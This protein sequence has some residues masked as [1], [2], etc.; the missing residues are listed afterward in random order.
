MNM[1]I[2]AKKDKYFIRNVAAAAGGELF[3]G[4]GLPVVV[5]STFLQI[6]LRSLGA[7]S[8]IVG[9]VPTFFFIG[10]SLFGLLAGYLTG[11]LQDK[12]KV[13]VATHLFGTLPIPAF[14]FFLLISGGG[15]NT[16]IVFLLL[17]G[18]FSLGVGLI[19][20]VW[21]NY[22]VKIFSETKIFRAMSVVMVTQSIAR[23]TCS[24]LILQTVKRYSMDPRASGFIFCIVGGVFLIGTCF[25]LLT[26][27]FSDESKVPKR[28]KNIFRHLR[29]T[30][31]L[32]FGNR[33]FLRFLASDIETFAVIGVISFYANYAV[34]Y[35]GISPAVASGLFVACLYGGH[36]T[37]HILFGWMDLLQLRG[38][39]LFG[40]TAA[41]IGIVC[42]LIFQSLPFLLIISYVL[43]IA[44]GIRFL[45]FPTAVKRI[46][47]QE[48]ATLYFSIAP[49]LV[50]PFSAGLPFV[51][52]V[53][54]D[55]LEHLGG[56]SYRLVF[57][58]Y[59]LVIGLAVIFLSKVRF[60]RR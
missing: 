35:C 32:A 59:G 2:E 46:S 54:L 39:F 3:W 56:L 15:N 30:S 16:I 41:A 12:R 14:G 6:F 55:G 60:P 17:Y 48:D 53:V 1:S 28:E 33:N 4:I 18:L 49:I 40:K 31:T 10:I 52:G 21:Q 11:H 25:Y 50:L 23:L 45:G 44:R 36:I 51:S 24:F 26:M 9:L 58:F 47:R 38:K 37:A 19:L 29:V 20:P 34:E 8:L 42:L 5:E 7:S 13:I 22:L 27:E 57:A 43:G